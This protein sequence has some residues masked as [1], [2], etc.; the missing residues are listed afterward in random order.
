MI[1]II[2]GTSLYKTNLIEDFSEEV[3]ETRYGRV[4]VLLGDGVI[5]IPRHGRGNDIPPHRINHKANAMAFKERNVEEIIGVTSVGSLK[6]EIKPMS[7]I[8]PNDYMNFWNI[9]TFYESE[10]MHITPELDESLRGIII[11]TAGK[12]GIKVIEKGIYVQ[13]T[14]PRLETKA[15][16]SLLKNYADIVGMNMASE[17]TLAK[18]LNLKY[19]NISSVDNYAHGVIEEKLDFRK[20]IEEASKNRGDLKRLLLSVIEELECQS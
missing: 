11:S 13:T 3:I 19:A 9:P 16:V 14:G 5:F 7:L 8:I 10:I 2:G 15:E 18:E 1:G 6:K 4:Y 20:V 17:A 12:L